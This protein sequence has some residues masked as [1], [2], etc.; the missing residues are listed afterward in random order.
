MKSRILAS[1]FILAALF[2]VNAKGI[3]AQTSIAGQFE[4]PSRN[5]RLAYNRYH[6]WRV[7]YNSL[8]V[9]VVNVSGVKLSP[10]E[11]FKILVSGL[12]NRLP[13]AVKAVKFNW[14]LFNVKDLNK[15]VENEQTHLVEVNLAPHEKRNVHIFIVNLEDI[16]L[17]RDKNPD[18]EFRLEVAV[19]EIHYEDGN[20][21]E[22]KELPAKL[23]PAKI[24]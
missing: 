1:I 18:G 19:T 21:W 6:R 5:W 13:K 4:A 8:L 16:P 11:K 10:A 22:A 17:L 14:Y 7:G 15:V 3:L 24:Q 12:N 20:V 9:E 23:D 2:T